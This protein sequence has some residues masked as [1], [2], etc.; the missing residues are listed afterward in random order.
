M[1]EL[2]YSIPETIRLVIACMLFISFVISGGL[3]GVAVENIIVK[4]RK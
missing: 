2:W 3:A 4:I 1:I